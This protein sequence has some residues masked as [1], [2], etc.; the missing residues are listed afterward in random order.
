VG[1]IKIDTTLDARGAAC[2]G[3]LME[4]IRGVR[5]A[6]IGTVIELLTS[7]KQATDDVPAWIEKVG[8][9][10]LGFKEYNNYW[11]IVVKKVK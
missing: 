6:D 8:N 4:L 10:F 7:E 9:E 3:A 1:D 5:A 2:P 11:S